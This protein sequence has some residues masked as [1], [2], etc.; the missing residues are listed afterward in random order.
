MNHMSTKTVIGLGVAAALAIAIAAGIS[1]SRQPQTQGAAVAAAGE[2]LPGLNEHVN[3]V[4]RIRLSAAGSQLIATLEKGDAGWTL[5]EKGGYRADAGKVR[6]LLLKLSQSRL[7]EQKTSNPQRYADVGVNDI[8]AADAKGVLIALEGLPQP[9]QLIVGTISP[10]G[11]ATYVRRAGEK[12]SW[13]AKGSLVPDRTTAN[14]L[15]KALVDIPAARV[16]ELVLEKPGAR[17]L[18]VSKAQESDT[19]Y[20][21]ADLPKGRELSS[22]FAANTLGTVLAGLQFDDVF[23]AADAAPPAAVHKARV[24]TF[25]G[26]VVEI[27]SWNKDGKAYAQLAARR[28]AA[29]GDAAIAAAQAKAKAE[30]DAQQ[31]AAPAASAERADKPAAPAA[32]LAV[33]DPAKDQAERVARSEA[34]VAELS[35]RF[36]GWTFVLPPHKFASLDS[37]VETLLKPLDDKKP[38]AGK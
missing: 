2:L 13:L 30:W 11:D 35:R 28:D 27:T 10:R 8:G 4:K 6:E 3:A 9:A 12:E 15:D 21:V 18:R 24:A 22:E 37:S 17:P 36:A 5:A 16:R 1:V 25:D 26:V 34:E 19:N 38:A 33:S 29:A 32:P 14:W 20:V 23:A 31:A 7:V